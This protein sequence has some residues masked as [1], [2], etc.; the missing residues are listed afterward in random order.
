[1][2]VQDDVIAMAQ[3]LERVEG[4]S[5]N[6][7]YLFCM[8]PVGPRNAQTVA[9]LLHYAK[10]YS[11]QRAVGLS[12]TAPQEPPSTVSGMAQLETL[13]QVCADLI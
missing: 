8:A 12:L 5:L 3:L 7:R 11:Q 4:L 1:M 6:D 9:A 2:V 13:H 10:R